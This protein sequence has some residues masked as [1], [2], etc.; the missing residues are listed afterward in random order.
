[1][2]SRNLVLLG[3]VIIQI[4]ICICNPLVKKGFIFVLFASNISTPDNAFVHIILCK[5]PVITLL[6]IYYFLLN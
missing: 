4:T 5:K 1:M 3:G 6:I 2:S